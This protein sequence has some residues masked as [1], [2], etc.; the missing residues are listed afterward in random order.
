MSKKKIIYIILAIIILGFLIF[1][2]MPRG[3]Q[4]ALV[5]P[6]LIQQITHSQP[7]STP[8]PTPIPTPAAPKNFQFNSSTDLKK[9]LDGVNP[10]VLDSD[11]EEK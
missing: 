7:S 1:I 9:E 8:K 5:G 6:T 3:L 11:F 2:L 10:L 4:G